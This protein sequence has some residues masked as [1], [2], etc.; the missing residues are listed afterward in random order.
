MGVRAALAYVV[1]A[2]A[3]GLSP[4]ADEGGGCTGPSEGGG[5]PP[6]GLADEIASTADVLST[7]VESPAAGVVKF[8][9][10]ATTAG[11]AGGGGVAASRETGNHAHACCVGKSTQTHSPNEENVQ[12]GQAKNA[13]PR[14]NRPN[15]STKH[16][17]M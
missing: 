12:G 4:P 11:A 3:D 14:P 8:A 7:V 2:V 1:V 15:H 6:R 10:P 5:P 13:W 16:V 17:S 9:S